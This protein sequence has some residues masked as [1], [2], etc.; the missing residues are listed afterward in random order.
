MIG[1]TSCENADLVTYPLEGV[2]HTYFKKWKKDRGADVEPV[3]WDE[4]V[5][6]FLDIF[7]SLDLREAKV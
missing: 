4:L 7:F 1:V 2:D 3:Q 6:E 5:V